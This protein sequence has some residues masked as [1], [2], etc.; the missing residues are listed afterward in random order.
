MEQHSPDLLILAGP[1]LSKDSELM[2]KDAV[3]HLS[4]NN[5]LTYEQLRKDN[6]QHLVNQ[7]ENYVSESSSGHSCRVIL[8]PDPREVDLLHPLPIPS[9]GF[10]VELRP[11]LFSVASSPAL[12]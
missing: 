4:K 7:L 8:V 6:F 5:H 3:M 9:S 11:D 2:K 12:I 10:K 1:F